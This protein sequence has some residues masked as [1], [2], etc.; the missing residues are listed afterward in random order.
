MFRLPAAEPSAVRHRRRYHRRPLEWTAPNYPDLHPER[1]GR[2]GGGVTLM[3]TTPADQCATLAQPEDGIS[4]R[5]PYVGR[6]EP[7]D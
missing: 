2:A 4:E 5:I 6:W 1:R 3:Q 7:G